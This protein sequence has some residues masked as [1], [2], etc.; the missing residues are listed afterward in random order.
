MADRK[1]LDPRGSDSA[2]KTSIAGDA[3]AAVESAGHG[4]NEETAQVIDRTAEKALCRK[5][6]FRLL[7]VLAIMVGLRRNSCDTRWAPR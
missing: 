1:D 6:D 3:I 4:F 7:P 2:D 5:F